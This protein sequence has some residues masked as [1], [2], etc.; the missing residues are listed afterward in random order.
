MKH[1]FL[2]PT[3]LGSQIKLLR[4]IKNF[5][6][7]FIAEKVGISKSYLSLIESG[8]RK[9]HWATIRL[10]LLELG[11]TVSTFLLKAEE[12]RFHDKLSVVS[13]SDYFIL[14]GEEQT[15]YEINYSQTQNTT[16]ILTTQTSLSLGVV[17]VNLPPK[18]L[19]SEDFIS[20]LG[21]FLITVENGKLLLELQYPDGLR[22]EEIIY[23]DQ[24]IYLD[25]N[26][27]YRFRNVGEENTTFNLFLPNL[28][29]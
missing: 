6:A 27:K 26:I 8:K 4:E 21:K 19:W 1:I 15:S 2:N 3:E 22:H 17:K 18:K 20:L 24:I 11:E 14:E 7:E 28:S 23:K 10:I 16:F 5:K 25:E 29:F 9:V 12:T 13:P